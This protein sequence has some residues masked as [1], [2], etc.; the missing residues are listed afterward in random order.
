MNAEV[1]DVEKLS[2]LFELSRAFSSLIEVEELLPCIIAK[3]RDGLQEVADGGAIFLD[4][5]GET[6]PGMQVKLLRVLQ[7]GEIRRVGETQARRVDVRVI[8]ATNRD[9]AQ[10][11]REK[12]FRE[13]L[14]YRISVFPIKIPPLEARREDIPLLVS[15]FI[16]RS[17]ERLGKQ[18]QGIARN[19]LGV[20][21][22]YPWPGNVRELQNEIERA[23]A[24][25]P[26]GGSI[27]TE[28]LSD[29]ITAER[30]LR[31]P[32]PKEARLLREARLTFEREYVA[33]VL[34]QNQGNAAKTARVL[35]IS[36]QMVQQKIKAY[37]SGPGCRPRL[38]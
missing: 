21:M 20:L 29:R 19:A 2:L 35:G 4:E 1:S 36:R 3:T 34:R 7:E 10:E 28:S 27:T 31:V 25:T 17:N 33:E 32:L 6:S 11:V 15:R 13:D 30:A 14:Y 8:S 24:L 26:D 12:R 18:V 16:R 37:G 5:I 23:V 38:P 22:S 9:L